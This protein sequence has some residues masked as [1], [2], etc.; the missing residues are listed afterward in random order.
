M[1]LNLQPQA[2]ACQV[3]GQPFTEGDRV[4]SYLVRSAALEIQRHDLLADHAAAFTPDGVIACRWVHAYK[5]RLRGDSAGRQLKLT[6]E[7]LFLTLAD[8]TTEQTE[9]TIRL[10]RFLALLLERKRVLRFKGN[11]KDGT[12]ASYEHARTKQMVEVPAGEFDPAFFLA[13]QAQLALLVGISAAKPA[14]DPAPVSVTTAK[15]S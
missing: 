3:T 5:V 7:N 12:K 15:N 10:V 1:E 11:S 13:M 6:A 9:E 14:G 8:P 4:A 2:T